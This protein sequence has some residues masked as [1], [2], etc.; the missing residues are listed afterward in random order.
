MS[1]E[2]VKEYWNYW[3]QIVDTMHGGLVLIRPDGKIVLANQ[4]MERMTGYRKEEIIDQLCTLFRCDSCVLL[5]KSSRRH[6]CT[7]FENPDGSRQGIKCELI[8]K[9]GSVLPVLK[10]ASVL[11]DSSGNVLGAVET[12]IDLSEIEKRDRKIEELSRR[13]GPEN[14]FFGMIGQ[15]QV[16]QRVY[17]LIEKAARSEAPVIIFGESGTGKE[18]VAHAIHQLSERSEGPFIQLNCAA[19]NESLLESELFGH[20]KGAFTGAYRHRIGRFEA[21]DGGHIFLDE[22]GEMPLPTQVKLLRVLETKKVERVGDHT[23]ISVDVRIIAATNRNLTEMVKGK[24]FREDLFFR[25][26]VIPIYLPPLRDRME[27][28]PL[29]AEAM[30]R[31][32]VKRTQKAIT[33]LS[34]SALEIFLSYPWHGNVRELKSALEFAFVVAE[35]GL[36]MPEHLP[37][38]LLSFQQEVSKERIPPENHSREKEQLIAALKK[39]GGNR[40]ETA[41]IL[42]VTRATVWNRIRKYNIRLEQVIRVS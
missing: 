2:E 3:P 22:I 11:K 30:I 12:V 16:M 15:S 21:A 7:L 5:R 33:G 39:A 40:S 4:A 24:K 19:L 10:N 1:I 41:R 27:D 9:D 38:H 37:G 28:V 35:S 17:Q 36:I 31:D 13:L 25:I 29:L 42:G 6:W 20:V 8:R 23:P 14:R 18:L 34:K 32:L 26:N